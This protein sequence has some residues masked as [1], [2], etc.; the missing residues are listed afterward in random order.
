MKHKGLRVF[1]DLQDPNGPILSPNFSNSPQPG[2][3]ACGKMKSSAYYLFWLLTGLEEAGSWREGVGW[4]SE[5]AGGG[6]G[7][8]LQGI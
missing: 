7:A 6:V 4:S 1:S 8:A 3:G 5:T 2:N